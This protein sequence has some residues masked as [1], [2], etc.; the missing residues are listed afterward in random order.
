MVGIGVGLLQG[1]CFGTDN[2]HVCRRLYTQP[3]AQVEHI[4][5]KHCTCYSLL[6]MVA[7]GFGLNRAISNLL[8][9]V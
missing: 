6:M 1:F 3:L 7:S 8:I 9:S 2:L 5:L 4:R